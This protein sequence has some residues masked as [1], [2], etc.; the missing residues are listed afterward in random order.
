MSH[1]FALKIFMRKFTLKLETEAQTYAKNRNKSLNKSKTSTNH[2]KI[3]CQPDKT[4]ST[5]TYS[6]S[7]SHKSGKHISFCNTSQN[8]YPFNVA[9]KD[10]V[11][12]F[13]YIFSKTY[14]FFLFVFVF[15]IFWLKHRLYIVYCVPVWC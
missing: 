8:P 1:V 12:L 6:S 9:H 11:G 3:P 2:T 7:I 10:F 5:Y 15:L 13:I 4:V 14:F